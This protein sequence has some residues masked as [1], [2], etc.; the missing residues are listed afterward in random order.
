MSPQARP[1]SW[2][3]LPASLVLAVSVAAV[4]TVSAVVGTSAAQ[5]TFKSGVSLVH[6]PVVVTGKDGGACSG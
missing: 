2:R 3:L 6:V 5:Q 4:M 1:S